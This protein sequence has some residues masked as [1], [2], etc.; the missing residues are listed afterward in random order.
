MLFFFRGPPYL[1]LTHLPTRDMWWGAAHPVAQIG[2]VIRLCRRNP[3]KNVATAGGERATGQKVVSLIHIFLSQGQ[4]ASK[5]LPAPKL[6]STTLVV[7]SV[8]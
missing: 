7:L 3:D 6:A 8:A 4:N 5:C 1:L 2:F